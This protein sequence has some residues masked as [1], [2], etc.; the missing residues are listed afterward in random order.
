MALKKRDKQIK[1]GTKTKNCY[2][3]YLNINKD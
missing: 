1:K 3:F 2:E